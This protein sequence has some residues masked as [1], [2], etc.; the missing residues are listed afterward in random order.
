M[1]KEICIFGDEF[2]FL[3]NFFGRQVII[4]NH[5]YPTN[6]H[7][8]QC[9]KTT[10]EQDF[11]YVASAPT[12][13]QAKRRG[14]SITLRDDWTDEVRQGVMYK[15]NLAKYAQHMDLLGKLLR[16]GDALLMEGNYH[17]DNYWGVVM[18][19]GKWVGQ[20]HLGKILMRIR[21]EFAQLLGLELRNGIYYINRY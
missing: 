7:A 18:V 11:L 3:S 14:Q 16:T 19:N 6:E 13:G 4:N 15:I 5:S 21:N 12:P 20:N 8:F 1:I 10:N 17:H 9:F 2:E